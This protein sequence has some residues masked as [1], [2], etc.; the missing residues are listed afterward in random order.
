MAEYSKGILGGFSGKVGTVIGANW[1]GKNIMRSLPTKKKRVASELQALQR[2]KFKLVSQFI[3][4]LNQLTGQY[5][6][7]YQG[8][9]S[10]TNLAMSHH[11][12]EAVEEVGGE[13]VMNYA[14]VVITKGVL[15]VLEMDSTV[16]DNNEL[17]LTWTS[18]ADAGLAKA[19]D[20]LV[21]VLYSKIHNL[22]YVVENQA[23]RAD[24]ALT[25][26]TPTDWVTNDNAVWICWVAE[27]G[28]NC[29]TS[30]YLGL[31]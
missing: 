6:G 3:A 16:L 13:F 22:F 29:S 19:T 26:P 5:F 4:P 15:P 9:K 17:Q 27:K 8:A 12:L 10:R 30:T 14:K 2:K 7:E 21:V 18:N 20:K 23:T 31:L 25:A 28:S 1:R 11:L 24:E